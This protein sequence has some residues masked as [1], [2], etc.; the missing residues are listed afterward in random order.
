MSAVGIT[1]AA[2]NQL[3]LLIDGAAEDDMV[4]IGLRV[5]VTGGGCSGFQ[6]GFA[7]IEE[8][9]GIQEDDSVYEHFT[10]REES[11]GTVG[12]ITSV[13]ILVDPMSFMYLENSVVD[14]RSD[15]QG[16]RF[17]I[18]NPNATATCGCDRSFSV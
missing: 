2:I 4:I 6:Y 3:S 8:S 7:F 5:Y 17:T 18:D 13:K 9:E 1:Q 14:Y 11:D 10:S 15:L 12:D 16:S